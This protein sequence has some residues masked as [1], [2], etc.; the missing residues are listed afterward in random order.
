MGV[1]I[2]VVLFNPVVFVHSYFFW[3]YFVA[4]CLYFFVAAFIYEVVLSGLVY[5]VPRF[6]HFLSSTRVDVRLPLRAGLCVA[7]LS[8]RSWNSAR[9]LLWTRGYLVRHFLGRVYQETAI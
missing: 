6:F 7:A 8:Y 1:C 4:V 9:C 3:P 5:A 2:F